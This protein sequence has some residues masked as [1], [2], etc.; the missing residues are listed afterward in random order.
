MA[1]LDRLI[2]WLEKPIS[3]LLWIAVV[4]GSLLMVHVSLDVAGRT[5]FNHPLPGTTEV[6][7]AYYMVLA[8]YLPW[9]WISQ[10][11]N[12]LSADLF[13]RMLPQ[14]LGFWLDS[15]VKVV[16]IVYTGTF[17]WQ[18]W[19]RAAQQTAAGEVWQAGAGYIPVWPSRWVLPLA[20]GLMFVYL[21]LR[22]AS[23]LAAKFRR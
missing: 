8:A 13:T 20:A 6:V 1:L 5:I 4:A 12:H 10:K 14:R 9:A 15:A 7:S 17:T 23:D 11:D 2:G 3:L 21:V 16:T 18:T 19:L 22:V